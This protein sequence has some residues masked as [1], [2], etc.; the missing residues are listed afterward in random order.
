MALKYRK[1]R[2]KEDHHAGS[3][4]FL[5]EERLAKHIGTGERKKAW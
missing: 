3:E 1:V 5:E 2:E 4:A